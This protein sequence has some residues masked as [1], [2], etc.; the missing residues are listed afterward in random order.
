[1]VDLM[2]VPLQ[3]LANGRGHFAVQEPLHGRIVADY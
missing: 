3:R 2:L 1:L